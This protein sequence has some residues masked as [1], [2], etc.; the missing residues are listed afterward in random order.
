MGS[1]PSAPALPNIAYKDRLLSYERFSVIDR[2]SKGTYRVEVSA[3]PYEFAVD[4]KPLVEFKNSKIIASYHQLFD[5]T[6]NRRIVLIGETHTNLMAPVDRRSLIREGIAHESNDILRAFLSAKKDKS[7]TTHFMIEQDLPLNCTLRIG[8][9]D[10][11]DVDPET[12]AIIVDPSFAPE[13]LP[14][15][16]P[17]SEILVIDYL[18]EQLKKHKRDL[19]P[20][21]FRNSL[22]DRSLNYYLYN[23]DH[24][25]KELKLTELS[26]E[27][28]IARRRIVTGLLV[29]VLQRLVIQPEI[30][31]YINRSLS[32]FSPFTSAMYRKLVGRQ[33]V[34][35]QTFADDIKLPIRSTNFKAIDFVSMEMLTHVRELTNRTIDFFGL[36]QLHEMPSNSLTFVYAGSAHTNFMAQMLQVHDTDFVIEHVGEY[37]LENR[38]QVP[39]PHEENLIA[40]NQYF[41]ICTGSVDPKNFSSTRGDNGLPDY[42]V[43]YDTIVFGDP[44]LS[45]LVIDFIRTLA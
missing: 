32:G 10:I 12:G 38:F 25:F 33:K 30:E 16:V 2:E 14:T 21:D 23:T 17:R 6:R 40:M 18:A 1:A 3:R 4:P 9:G 5:P 8:G 7:I 15:E 24:V 28:A 26:L 11:F 19:R 41:K 43:S 20:F 35:L 39:A 45:K 27:H 13:G 29:S 22:I 34:L 37:D 42:R 44:V 31:R 36:V